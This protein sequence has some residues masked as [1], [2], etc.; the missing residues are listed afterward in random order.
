MG[1]P[2]NMCYH[3]PLS[4]FK[5]NTNVNSDL[6]NVYMQVKQNICTLVLLVIFDYYI[7]LCAFCVRD[8]EGFLALSFPHFTL[9]LSSITHFR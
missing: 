1:C 8:K 5:T 6:N 4:R 3:K 9:Q 7:S 2:L